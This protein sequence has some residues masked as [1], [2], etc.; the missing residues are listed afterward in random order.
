M[1]ALME[2]PRPV[3][4]ASALGA[5]LLLAAG[6]AVSGLYATMAAAEQP[7]VARSPGAACLASVLASGGCPL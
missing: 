1:G 7:E 6:L 5:L 3:P 2:Q 4:T